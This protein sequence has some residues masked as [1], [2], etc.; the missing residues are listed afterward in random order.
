MLSNWAPRAEGGQRRNPGIY[1][2]EGCQPRNPA[3]KC[4]THPQP[5]R[6][7]FE[8]VAEYIENEGCTV[9]HQGPWRK[10]FTLD[11]GEELGPHSQGPWPKSLTL[12]SVEEVRWWPHTAED[13][14]YESSLVSGGYPDSRVPESMR[15]RH[16][17]PSFRPAK[18]PHHNY[19]GNLSPPA[20]SGSSFR[21]LGDRSLGFQGTNGRERISCYDEWC[22]TFRLQS[23]WPTAPSTYNMHYPHTIGSLTDTHGQ[24]EARLEHLVRLDNIK[25]ARSPQYRSTAGVSDEK[26]VYTIPSEEWKTLPCSDDESLGASPSTIAPD[27][28]GNSSDSD[29]PMHRGFSSEDSPDTSSDND[30]PASTPSGSDQPPSPE[31][32][33]LEPPSSPEVHSLEVTS[34]EPASSDESLTSADEA[35]CDAHIILKSEQRRSRHPGVGCLDLPLK[36]LLDASPRPSGRDTAHAARSYTQSAKCLTQALGAEL[37]HLEADMNSL[38]QDLMNIKRKIPSWTCEGDLVFSAQ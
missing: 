7:P 27:S 17:L 29:T 20:T 23:A 10:S 14:S 30:V 36:E 35:P 15:I 38:T 19:S 6:S 24:N 5:K 33:S 25:L 3:N 13:P 32:F 21:T 37:R 2:A 16:T 12:E 4:V 34:L 26:S 28:H 31:A 11:S 9:P 8:N 18:D 22:K 1:S